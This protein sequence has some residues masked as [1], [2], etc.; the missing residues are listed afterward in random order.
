MSEPALVETEDAGHDSVAVEP[1][2]DLFVT[3]WLFQHCDYQL[4]TESAYARIRRVRST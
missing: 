4:W 1:R 3:R 2:T